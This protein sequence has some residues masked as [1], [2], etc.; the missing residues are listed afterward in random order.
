MTN[1]DVL[2]KGLAASIQFRLQEERFLLC[3]GTSLGL[4]LAGQLWNQFEVS[5]FMIVAKTGEITVYS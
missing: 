5:T 3:S 4:T 2:C 1:F